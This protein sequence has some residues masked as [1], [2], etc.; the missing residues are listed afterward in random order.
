MKCRIVISAEVVVLAVCLSLVLAPD[1]RAG[2]PAQV[3]EG[4]N[5]CPRC[6]NNEDRDESRARNN[7]TNTTDYDRRD[8]S[9]V[10]GYDGVRDAFDNPPPFTEDGQAL[11][12]ATWPEQRSQTG[13][14]LYGTGSEKDWGLLGCDPLGWPRLHSY[15]YGMEFV[16]L[17]DRVLQFFEFQHSW[18]TIWTDGRPLPEDPPILN[19]MGWNIGY[20]EGDT[21][22]IE[23]NGYDNR[24]WIERTGA[25]NDQ[26]PGGLPHSDQMQIVERWTR[27]TYGTLE[28]QI[29]ITDPVVFT[30]PFVTETGTIGLVP[31][32]ELW[33]YQCVASEEAEFN[34]RDLVR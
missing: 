31:G 18:R 9:G 23:S 10:W 8:L 4:W 22:V 12:E 29:T 1:S 26:P 2:A 5:P 21:F 28:A 20:W 11:F 34:E 6:Q 17:P 15:N 16:M 27:P 25:R 30:E 14:L 7:I 32:A 13:E 19:W 3:P 24:S 33:E